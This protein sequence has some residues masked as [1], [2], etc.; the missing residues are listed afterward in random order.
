MAGIFLLFPF[1]LLVLILTVSCKFSTKLIAEALTSKRAPWAQEASAAKVEVVRAASLAT[2]VWGG[3]R[4]A[5]ALDLNK[6]NNSKM[7]NISYHWYYI[8]TNYPDLLFRKA[9]LQLCYKTETNQ[10]IRSE[11]RI[12][13]QAW[14]LCEHAQCVVTCK[15]SQ[16]AITSKPYTMSD[17]VQYL[18]WF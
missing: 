6:K 5:V 12:S 13:L 17:C 8:Q 10:G 3:A 9:I 11:N 4:G 14:G 2:M 18:L 7:F 15:V 16:C 1:L